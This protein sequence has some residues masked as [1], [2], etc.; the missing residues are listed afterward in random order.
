M[1]VQWEAGVAF[2][3]VLVVAEPIPCGLTESE[4]NDLASQAHFFV[5]GLVACGTIDPPS[6]LDNYRFTAAVGTTYTFEVLA[7]RLGHPTDPTLALL[8]MDGNTVVFSD[9]EGG[10]LD[11]I[12][13]WAAPAAGQYLLQ[14][15]SFQNQS[16]GPD[17][18]YQLLTSQ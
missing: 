18:S 16:G 17:H 1:Q 6:D 14:V 11:P 13:T 2:G 12:L 8:D 7:S 3:S 15:A 9:D 4:P 10:L 5:P